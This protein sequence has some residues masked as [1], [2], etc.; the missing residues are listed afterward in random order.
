MSLFALPDC[1]F[2]GL[3]GFAF[4]CP[5][6]FLV[7]AGFILGLLL[8]RHHLG[9]SDSCVFHLSATFG[10]LCLCFGLLDVDRF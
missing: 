8:M 3:E 10:S 6:R 9:G 5:W 4:G 1:V 7:L 2:S